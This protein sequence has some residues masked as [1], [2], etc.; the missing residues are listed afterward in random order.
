MSKP[1][2]PVFEAPPP[3]PVSPL[4]G[5]PLAMVTRPQTIPTPHGP[6]D[7]FLAPE[8]EIALD[9]PNV[10]VRK[11]DWSAGFSATLCHWLFL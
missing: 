6:R 7:V 9:G 1:R 3:E 8:Y 5:L 11:G 2:R 10:R 4:P